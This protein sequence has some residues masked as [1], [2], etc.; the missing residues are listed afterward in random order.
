MAAASVLGGYFG[1]RVSRKMNR[2][3]VRWIVVTIGVS[4]ATYY[5]MR[6]A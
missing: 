3:V 2:H 1:A 5:F 4:L 6:H